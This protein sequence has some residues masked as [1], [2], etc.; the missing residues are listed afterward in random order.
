ME[1]LPRSTVIKN[2]TQ[3]IGQLN[4][5]DA[6]AEAKVLNWIVRRTVDGFEMEAGPRHAKGVL[7]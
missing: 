7:G 2:K 6:M 5:D 1:S 3:N 4:S